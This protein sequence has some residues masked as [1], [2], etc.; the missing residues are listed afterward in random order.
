M[1]HIRLCSKKVVKQLDNLSTVDFR[2]IDA[3]IT[4]LKKDPRPRGAKKLFDDIY[5][6]RVGNYRIIYQVNDAKRLV[7]I[8]KIGRRHEH[9]YKDAA[10]LFDRIPD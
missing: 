3:K 4:Q 9:T 7:H 6:I 1:Y 5:R 8:G 10:R 2:R